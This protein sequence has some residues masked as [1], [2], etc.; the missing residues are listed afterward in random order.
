MGEAAEVAALADVWLNAVAERP[1]LLHPLVN[2]RRRVSGYGS[3]RRLCPDG[4][5]AD[6]IHCCPGRARPSVCA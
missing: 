5:L 2:A 1:G 3:L 6:P 4:H